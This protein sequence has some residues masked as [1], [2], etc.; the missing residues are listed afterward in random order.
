MSTKQDDIPVTRNTT[1]GPVPGSLP[2][3]RASAPRLTILTPCLNQARHLRECLDSILDQKYPDLQL[4]VL[5]GGS[6]DDSTSILESYGAS[7][8]WRSHPDCGQAAAINE[9]LQRADGEIIGWLN[10]D[11]YYLPHAFERVVRCF[12]EN[13]EAD[14]VY[15]RALMV[16]AHGR[17]SREY[18][19]FDFRRRAL[20]R[21]CYVCQPTVFVRR[22][23]LEEVG[24][25][26]ERL[27]VCLDYDWWLRISRDHRL[28]FCDHLLAASRHYPST[29][30]V[31]AL[32]EAGYL[33][34]HHFGKASWRWSA[35]W[36]V[37]RWSLDRRRF[38]VPLVGWVAALASARRYRRRFHAAH[39][40]SAYGRKVLDGLG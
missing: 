32:V 2:S 40:P 34:R 16:D 28:V 37:H 14:M 10:G 20:T 22:R 15:G 33:M 36:V 18:P 8:W 21:K 29:K 5:D 3:P 38:V 6:G 25:L 19:T 23:V 11:D 12:A 31:R 26:N 30:T 24:P 35:K 9:G 7:L 27:D 17:T 13:P 4:I 1:P 39:R